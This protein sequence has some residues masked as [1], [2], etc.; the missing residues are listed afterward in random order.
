MRTMGGS[1]M[2]L[3]F[4]DIAHPDAEF[5]KITAGDF[6]ANQLLIADY[7]GDIDNAFSGRDN[8]RVGAIISGTYDLNDALRKQYRM[9]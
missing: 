9:V 5:D 6:T 4:L 8:T 3:V 1:T 7:I 2:K